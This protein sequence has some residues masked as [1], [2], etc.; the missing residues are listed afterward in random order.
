MTRRFSPRSY[1]RM[2]K[3]A[4]AEVGLPLVAVVTPE[5]LRIEFAP[6]APVTQDGPPKPRIVP[7]DKSPRVRAAA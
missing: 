7:D 2:A 6:P 4:A 5:G 3:E 1:A